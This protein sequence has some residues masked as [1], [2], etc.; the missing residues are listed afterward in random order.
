MKITVSGLT[1]WGSVVKYL[2]WTNCYRTNLRVLLDRQKHRRLA[3][4]GLER[5]SYE[6]VVGGSN[7]SPP[8][9]F[10]KCGRGGM[11]YTVDSKSTALKAYGFDSHRSHQILRHT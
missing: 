10:L 11:A 8:T 4:S 1:L 7:P 9:I 3:Q 5:L 2:L 6:Q